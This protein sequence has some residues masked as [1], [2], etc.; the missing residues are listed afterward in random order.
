MEGLSGGSKTTLLQKFGKASPITKQET[1]K[2]FFQPTVMLVSAAGR[3]VQ[4]VLT[5]ED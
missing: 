3:I 1:Q 5:L 4:F 2:F